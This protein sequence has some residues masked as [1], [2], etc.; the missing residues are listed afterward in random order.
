MLNFHRGNLKALALLISLAF[1][2]AFAGSANAGTGAVHMV[3]SRVGFILGGGGGSGTLRFNGH[4]YSLHV[5]GVS[6]GATIGVSRTEYNGRALHLKTASD[7]AGTYTAL[8][9]GAALAAGAGAVIL[10]NGKGVVLELTG[11]K[12]GFEASLAISGLV[13]SLR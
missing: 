2:P 1:L 8:G 11:A 10:Q 5:S 6:F 3:V 9:G 4:R 13:I 7:I 12:V